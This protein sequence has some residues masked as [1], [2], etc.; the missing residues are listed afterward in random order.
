[1]DDTNTLKETQCFFVCV[2]KGKP[3]QYNPLSKSWEFLSPLH[4]GKKEGG[5]VKTIIPCKA[6]T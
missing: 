5:I 1:M 2:C 4:G 3:F 6:D